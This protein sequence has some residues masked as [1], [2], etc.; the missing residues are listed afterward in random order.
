MNATSVHSLQRTTPNPLS[1]PGF[2]PCVSSPPGHLCHTCGR[3][4]PVSQLQAAWGTTPHHAAPAKVGRP[5]AQD[6]SHRLAHANHTC[7][8]GS[9]QWP[10]SQPHAVWGTMND[11][12]LR[13]LPHTGCQ[14]NTSRTILPRRKQADHW[15][16]TPPTDTPILAQPARNQATK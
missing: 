3:E 9:R 1:C 12:A 6:P 8:R 14:P 7:G 4:W 15:R 5:L 16:K 11:Y 13:R 2:T 10:V